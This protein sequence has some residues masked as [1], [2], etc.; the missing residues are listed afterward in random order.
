MATHL[1][2]AKGQILA[3][4]AAA[5]F[6]SLGRAFF[7]GGVTTRDC[8]SLQEPAVNTNIVNMYGATET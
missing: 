4:G 3:G 5:K 6:P 7:V 1:A 8:R 2:P